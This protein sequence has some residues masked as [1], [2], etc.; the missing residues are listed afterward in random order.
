MQQPYFTVD[1]FQLSEDRRVLFD[2]K[3]DMPLL[4]SDHLK[5][6]EWF[7]R[8]I[9]L[10][11][12]MGRCIK[13]GP[14]RVQVHEGVSDAPEKCMVA[15]DELKQAV[16][17]E[18]LAPQIRP[19]AAIKDVSTGRRED[20]DGFMADKTLD[21]PIDERENKLRVELPRL[22]NEMPLLEQVSNQSHQ[23]LTSHL[24]QRDIFRFGD[25]HTDDTT[26]NWS[27]IPRRAIPKE[28]IEEIEPACILSNIAL[29]PEYTVRSDQMLWK[30]PGLRLLDVDEDEVEELMADE[31]LMVDEE[32]GAPPSDKA[33]EIMSLGKATD[34][35]RSCSEVFSQQL[36]PQVDMGLR[37]PLECAERMMRT[38]EYHPPVIPL[39]R[40]FRSTDNAIKKIA[41]HSILPFSATESL[42]SFLDLR[43]HKFKK[44]GSSSIQPSV[45]KEASSD[46]I[47]VSQAVGIRS[48]ETTEVQVPSTPKSTELFAHMP[49]PRSYGLQE[50]CT[51]VADEKLVRYRALV[52]MLDEHSDRNLTTIYRDLESSA[53]LILNPTTCLIF[54]NAQALTQRSLP[55]QKSDSGEEGLRS[56]IRNLA[57]AF[58]TVFVLISMPGTISGQQLRVMLSVGAAFTSFT[59]L[60]HDITG[61]NGKVRLVWVP[62]GDGLKSE[63]TTAPFC[64][65]TWSLICRYA[66]RNCQVSC[67]E[68]T[69]G[70][71][72]RL[73]LIQE[74]SVW[75]LF[76]RRCG[77]NAMAAQVVL[78]MLK[79]ADTGGGGV[80]G[81]A[82]GLRHFPRTAF[83]FFQYFFPSTHQRLRRQILLFRN[84][85]LAKFRFETLPDLRLR[86]Q[87]RVYRALV[88]RQKRKKER[89][90]AGQGLKSG[91]RR[92]RIE[93]GSVLRSHERGFAAR[94]VYDKSV[95]VPDHG[96][97]T[98]SANQS[99]Y[100]QSQ[101]GGR[102]PASKMGKVIGYLRAANEIRQTYQAH[103]N[104]NEQDR[105]MPADF[106]DIDIVRSGDEEMIL[107][108]SYAKRHMKRNSQPGGKGQ[109]SFDPP[110]SSSGDLEYWK[111][112]WERFEDEN[113]VVDVDVRGWI[114][115]PQKGPLNRKN[116][117]ALA[118]ARRLSGVA[119]DSP[120]LSRDVS[121]LHIDRGAEAIAWKEAEQEAERAWRGAYS[122]RPGSEPNS[123]NGSPAHSRSASRDATSDD[124]I[125]LRRSRFPQGSSYPSQAQMS[126]S[127]MAKANDLLLTRLRPFMSNPLTNTTITIF[128]FNNE[129][130][131]SKTVLTN[132]S[133]HFNV[134]AALDFV[135]SHVR[136]LAGENLS[137][138]EDVKIT[139]NGGI[140]LIS[141][142]DDTIKHSAISSGPREIFKNTFVRDLREL[143]IKGVREW[144]STLA[145][146]GVQMHYVSNS[147]W[148]LYPLLK[149]YFALAGLPTGS[150]HLKQYSGML[151][152]I[153]EP[154][155]ERKKGTIER[156]MAD[157]PDKKFI[158][159]G[160]SGEADLEVYTDAVVAHPNQVLAIFI[161]DVTS[162]PQQGFFDQSM[163][164]PD[165]K[166]PEGDSEHLWLS[167]DGP[168]SILPP[169]S[170]PGPVKTRDLI[171]FSDETSSVRT[172]EQLRTTSYT[173]DLLQL[174]GH[175]GSTA[176]EPPGKPAKPSH[177]RASL[178]ASTTPTSYSSIDS[179]ATHGDNSKKPPPPPKPRQF[180]KSV[181]VPNSSSSA[182]LQK[183][184]PTRPFEQ[185]SNTIPLA[186]SRP[187][188]YSRN[189]TSSYRPTGSISS[190]AQ[191]EGYIQSARRQITNAY[192]ALPSLSSQSDD[193]LDAGAYQT[194]KKEELWRRRWARSEEIMRQKGVVFYIMEPLPLMES[195]PPEKPALRR[196]NRDQRRDIL[197]MRSLG[198][199]YEKIAA[200]LNVT[201]RAVQY[202]CIK[203]DPTPQHRRAGRRRKTAEKEASKEGGDE[204]SQAS[205]ADTLVDQDRDEDQDQE[206]QDQEERDQEERKQEERNQEERKQEERN[207]VERNQEELEQE[208]PQ[209]QLPLASPPPQ[210]QSSLQPL[211]Q[212]QQPQQPQLQQPQQ[213]Q[214]QQ[215]LPQN[216]LQQ[217][218][219]LQPQ[220]QPLLYQQQP[221][222]Q[223]LQREQRQ[224]HHLQP[225]PQQP[226]QLAM[227]P[228]H[229]SSTSPFPGHYPGAGL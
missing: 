179:E 47:H 126:Q 151:Q 94:A 172:N 78:A 75:E 54:T 207:Q 224:Q 16:R 183:P 111:R 215:Q 204:A 42:A 143:T 7:R 190:T 199:T 71:G 120:S 137:A 81:E 157:F 87:S 169:R 62:N 140:S 28:A 44:C 105:S 149:S 22:Q 60:Y 59:A 196:L 9:N 156:I 68:Q 93:L 83:S 48:S 98:M 173:D 34:S 55:G 64:S 20:L 37:W 102:V 186:Q 148:Q 65:W 147:P 39:K 49:A 132:E 225:K 159:V 142:I 218:L 229:S 210:S 188:S 6:V 1:N 177:L 84:G 191:D 217:P 103:R 219:P 63:T 127:E 152:W 216:P 128:F 198:Y 90:A 205:Q 77:M 223:P 58:D 158:L 38:D 36:P 208:Q 129:K 165:S 160:D 2:L 115:L 202:T 119:A 13:I 56:R 192:N 27:P 141:D 201:C 161:R 174:S 72:V 134:R 175:Y 116:R 185:K 163:W 118:L 30:E 184:V 155:A 164:N 122:T 212:Q 97:G 92:G 146:M 5:D 206:E 17:N 136:V 18:R 43:G 25:S 8:N 107:F 180:S 125:D 154:P 113:A 99:G 85:R 29:K 11:K 220:P 79:K 101:S 139:E 144:F 228:Q 167:P 89:R 67:A 33:E 114:Y 135:P 176:P 91:F 53:D 130:S 51:I 10:E 195:P 170:K 214:Q 12:L 104:Q 189:S 110:L 14:R 15:L 213:Q 226:Q 50:P 41:K 133:G 73:P 194:N 124:E 178:V 162:P 108:P 121:P 227:P 24:S 193:P 150:I 26:L 66:F 40:G 31:E 138:T 109:V 95:T 168:Q 211:Q 80:A 166:P 181:S 197:L 145:D 96:I 45:A 182:Q 46:P 221:L 3:M 21:F 117:L 171:D 76:L 19:F 123:R 32:L 88:N 4:R 200:H 203:K 23:L 187:G 153:S 106:A 131:E 222:Q 69:R 82:F 57:A 86:A 74:V 61:A 209:Q 100:A 70:N 52:S 35:S 112:Q